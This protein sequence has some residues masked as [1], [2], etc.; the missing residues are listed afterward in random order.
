V[1]RQLYQ[2]LGL[3]V[4][5]EFGA[6]VDPGIRDTMEAL[7]YHHLDVFFTPID[8]IR[9]D[10]FDFVGWVD[11][12]QPARLVARELVEQ[13][14][15][16]CFSTGTLDPQK[17]PLM[18]RLNLF[19]IR[20]MRARTLLGRL[21]SRIMGFDYVTLPKGPD[22]LLAIVEPLEAEL[23]KAVRNIL[24]EVERRLA[25]ID[26]LNMDALLGDPEL[27]GRVQSLLKMRWM[28]A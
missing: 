1:A 13:R 2:D 5:E 22:R 4:I 8:F 6:V 15:R 16:H 24:P 23:G 25:E 27:K 3:P 9:S 20:Q 10:L 21:V 12:G 19:G 11:N 18:A 26:E 14:F 7:D 28:S 17:M